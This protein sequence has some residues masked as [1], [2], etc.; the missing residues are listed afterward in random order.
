MNSLIK[1]KYKLI[2]LFFLSS[3]TGTGYKQPYIVT[4]QPVIQEIKA[5]D[6][7]VDPFLDQPI[8]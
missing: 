1:N 5:G 4:D 8:L 2:L 3:C 6:P 7:K